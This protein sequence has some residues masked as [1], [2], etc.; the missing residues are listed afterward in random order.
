MRQLIRILY[1]MMK[2]TNGELQSLKDKSGEKL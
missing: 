2:K 1:S